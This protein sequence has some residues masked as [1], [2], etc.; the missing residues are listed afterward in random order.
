[1]EPSFD[2]K[3]KEAV[4][5]YMDS[6]GWLTEHNK[7]KEFEKILADYV[8]IKYCSVLCN[9]TATLITALKVLGVEIGDEVIVPDYTMAAT[10][11]AVSAIGAKPVFVDVDDDTLGIN[12]GDMKKKVT[13]KTK[14]V[15]LVSI[16]GRYPYFGDNI[17]DYC[18]CLGIR[19]IEDA[20]QSLGS[21]HDDYHI[22]T[23]GEVGSFSFSMPK[24]ITSGQGGALVTDDKELHQKIQ[25][26]KNFG[27]K[28]SGV[29]EHESIGLN[30]KFTD[31][32]AVVGIE[33]MKKLHWRIKRK[34]EIFKYYRELLGDEL[35]IETDLRDTTPWM[36]DVVVDNRNK[37]GIFLSK[38]RIG[39]RPFY[40]TLHTQKPYANTKGKFE[41]ST[42]Y[43]EHGMWLPSS[44][45][46]SD[47]E[48]EY[49]CRKVKE[50]LK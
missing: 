3:E 47:L 26:Y 40:P 12:L 23:F 30:F 42:Y 37:L 33:Q 32:Q 25:M 11:F 50:G 41:T 38:N 8:G 31:L 24:I 1:M 15:M 39:T 35:F 34:K 9:G 22:G 14:A 13:K 36:N 27:R 20:A 43:S 49:V 6:G 48:V 7:T 4:A 44:V 19:V 46:L 28:T 29:D 16:N 10:A 18:D 21:F 5:K 17:I 2:I 45:K